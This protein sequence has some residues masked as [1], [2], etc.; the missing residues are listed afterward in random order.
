VLLE[1]DLRCMLG[2]DCRLSAGCV[3][4]AAGPSQQAGLCMISGLRGLT[5]VLASYCQVPLLTMSWAVH[6]VV[7]SK[8]LR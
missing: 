8:V 5:A 1:W 6:A 7:D 3:L 4:G 2:F